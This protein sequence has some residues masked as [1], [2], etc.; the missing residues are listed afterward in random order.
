MSARAL[1][2]AFSGSGR[3][4]PTSTASPIPNPP[5][6]TPLAPTGPSTSSH[7][8]LYFASAALASA[9]YSLHRSTALTVKSG[10][11]VPVDVPVP[12]PGGLPEGQPAAPA[13]RAASNSAPHLL[14]R[15]ITRSEEPRVGKE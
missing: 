3:Y 15:V 12:P 7:L 13:S 2:P 4:S 14:C 9:W 11:G 10:A 5:G 6:L 1:R 8:P